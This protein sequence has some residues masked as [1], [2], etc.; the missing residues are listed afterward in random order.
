M[1][2]HHASSAE[3]RRAPCASRSSGGQTVGSWWRAGERRA[4][5][6]SWGQGTCL[7]RAAFFL[8]LFFLVFCH[9]HT[10]GLQQADE[11]ANTT[12]LLES[13]LALARDS[14]RV[15]AT[16]MRQLVH[17]AGA[18]QSTERSPQQ[19]QLAR[20]APTA[21]SATALPPA[22]RSGGFSESLVQNPDVVLDGLDA[23]ASD[24]I[25]SDAVTLPEVDY[26]AAVSTPEELAAA[27]AALRLDDGAAV[28]GVCAA[29]GAAQGSGDSGD[30][31]PALPSPSTREGL[32]KMADLQVVDWLGKVC[33][34][35]FATQ[36]RWTWKVRTDVCPALL[37][38]A[39]S[40][41]FT[42]CARYRLASCTQ[43][44]R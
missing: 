12:R 18:G 16:S 1:Q 10:R 17:G 31:L 5:H 13:T 44:R 29:E 27:A 22:L 15:A 14:N 23:R 26:S 3:R 40:V 32:M 9:S 38:R 39:L 8:L 4:R 24:S 21:R 33:F 36:W 20:A 6:Q 37:C 19:R 2:M 25:S 28:E 35:L 43:S 41:G 42:L 7:G 30:G 11:A 34:S